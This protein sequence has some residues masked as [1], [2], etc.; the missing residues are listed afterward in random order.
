MGERA[1]ACYPTCNY[2]GSAMSQR[3]PQQDPAATQ[4]RESDA[5]VPLS[6]RAGLHAKAA[7]KIR[8][9]IIRGTL[10]AGLDVAETDLCAKLG[11]SRTP[12]REAMKLLAAERLV[13]LRRNRS[14]RITEIDA[15]EVR[16][17]FEA[18]ACIERSAA[19]LAAMR[20]EARELAQ[21]SR[22]QATLERHHA[23]DDLNAYFAAN[24]K[25]H[26]TIVAASKNTVLSATHAQLMPR[27]ERARCFALG[28]HGRWEE[29]IAEHKAILL[30]LEAGD[31]LRAG[32]L[33][34]DHVRRTGDTVCRLI[35]GERN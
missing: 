3:P 14:A 19:E 15:N 21:L 33:L 25:V 12:L 10:P 23:N 35:E 18:V 2:R 34:G 32:A 16:D 29:S 4:R 30:S 11:M 6:M 13:K 20:I 24:Q 17:L 31:P 28:A 7:A 27:V 1:Q 5:R 26:A 9:M 22:L 8:R